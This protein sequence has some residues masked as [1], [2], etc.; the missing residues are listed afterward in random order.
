MQETFAKYAVGANLL[1]LGSA[2]TKKKIQNLDPFFGEG[3][4]PHQEQ[5]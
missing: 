3:E 1:R 4:P 2:K 5:I